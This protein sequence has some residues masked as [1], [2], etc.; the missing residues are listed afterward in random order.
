[1]D[2]FSKFPLGSKHV[3]FTHCSVIIPYKLPQ[4]SLNAKNSTIPMKIKDFQRAAKNVFFAHRKPQGFLVP[5]IS[6]F[7]AY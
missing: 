2:S 4:G 1:L 3:N 7:L 6:D 5:K